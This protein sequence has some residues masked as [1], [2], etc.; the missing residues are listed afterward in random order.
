MDNISEYRVLGGTGTLLGPQSNAQFNCVIELVQ[1]SL[2]PFAESAMH[3]GIF[4]EN[5]LNSLLS[6]YIS[7]TARQGNLPYIVQHQSIEDLTRGDS[8]APDIG[9]HLDI[10]DAASPPPKITVF[11]GKRLTKG[12]GAKRH[13]EYVFGY[14]KKGKHVP[15]GGIERFKRSIHGQNLNQAGI[16]GYIQEETPPYWHGQIN[17]WISELSLQQTTP[18]WTEEERLSPLTTEGRISESTSVV[19]REEAPFQLTHLW[20][21][22]IET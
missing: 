4:S 18:K 19:S 11:E 3:G 9:I 17:F 12:L 2:H 1:R 21:N 13:R 7:K 15:C 5:G 8:P 20:V 14:E 10:D 6:L 22:L 16:I